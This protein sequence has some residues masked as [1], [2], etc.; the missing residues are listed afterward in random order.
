MFGGLVLDATIRVKKG[1]AALFGAGLFIEGDPTWSGTVMLAD[2]S[3]TLSV[4]RYKGYGLRAD[5]TKADCLADLSSRTRWRV[6]LR[7]EFV[8]LYID[9][10]LIQC[11]AL[12]GRSSGRV[13]FVVES[14]RA[15]L[16][17][18]IVR[19]MQL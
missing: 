16:G 6:L 12:P 14:C 7:R 1:Y 5:D 15:V 8:E 3:A 13:G 17:N 19:E 9:D 11:Y 4:G 10:R 2:N 18:I